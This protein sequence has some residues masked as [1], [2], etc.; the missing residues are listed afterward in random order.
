MLLQ[1]HDGYIDLL[2]ALP[3]IWADGYFKGLRVRGGAEVDAA[4]SDKQLVSVTLKARVANIYHLKKPDDI[5]I[6]KLNGEKISDTDGLFSIR[7]DAGEIAEL[8]FE[9]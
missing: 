4:W 9:K 6:V 1:S 3:D 2:P 5:R 8:I 7:L